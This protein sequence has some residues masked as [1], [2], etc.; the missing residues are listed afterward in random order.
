MSAAGTRPAVQEV[1]VVYTWVNDQDPD[2]QQLHAHATGAF[3][4]AGSLH[5]SVNDTARFQNREEIRF[6]INALRRYAPWVRHIF[7][8]TNCALPAWAED[9]PGISRVD[10][11]DIFPDSSVLPT[12]NAFAIEACLHRIDGLAEHFIY[13]N[14]D[15]FLMDHFEISEFFPAPGEVSVFLSRHDIPHA[16][17]EDLRPV[18]YSMLNSRQIL[19]ERFGF[20]PVK[21]LQHAP[22][23]L[24]RSVMYEIEEAYSAQL[25]QTR[26]HPFREPSD[27]P[28]STTL[29]AYWCMATDRGHLS[30]V[31]GRYIDI[32][33]PLFLLLVMPLSPLR[34][35]RYRFL[36]L[37]EVNS[38]KYFAGLRDR[39]VVNL[40]RKLFPAGG[41]D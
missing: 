12:F 24:V 1:D 36:C 13:F 9:D 11:R 35:G 14:D 37:N 39:I 23:P 2:W 29:H 5:S 16:W 28:L 27:L 7:I 31:P 34:R 10:H 38:M 8:V 6:S 32:G 3:T 19:L 41:G 33:D 15:V 26:S 40:M 30:D 17:R 18:E 25:V 22:F 20:N 4:H 21:K